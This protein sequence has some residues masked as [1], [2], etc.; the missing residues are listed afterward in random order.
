M[1]AGSRNASSCVFV[2]CR[3]VKDSPASGSPNT[4]RVEFYLI[5]SKARRQK[6]ATAE[7]QADGSISRCAPTS[8]GERLVD[9]PLPEC[10][11]I[12]AVKRWMDQFL[13]TTPGLS[14]QTGAAG[15]HADEEVSHCG[16]TCQ[17]VL[18]RF[19]PVYQL[20]IF[21]A[22]GGC[23]WWGNTPMVL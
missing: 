1:P 12:A 17:A 23:I 16:C 20:S 2:C 11:Q 15:M 7:R 19:D 6:V 13:A 9:T 21:H 18:K 8:F 22:F 4:E 14:E 10:T 3:I 5:D